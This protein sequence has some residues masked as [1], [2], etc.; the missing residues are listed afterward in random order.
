MKNKLLILMML[1]VFTGICSAANPQVTL[2]LSGAV[3][4]DIVLEIYADKA[5]VTAANFLNYV[6]T[7]FYDGLI[8]HRV[9]SGFMVQGGGFDANL[10]YKTA[11]SEIINESTNGLSN[12]RGTLAMARLT[13]PH[14]ASSQ[15]FINHV[16]N[17]FLDFGAV[18]YNAGTAYYRAGYCVFG[19]VLSGLDIVDAIAVLPTSTQNEM[20][21]VPDNDVIIH[22]VVTFDP[23]VC[24][25][26]E[27][28]DINGD[29]IVDLLDFLILAE[30]WLYGSIAADIDI[31]GKINYDDYSMFASHWM[32]QSCI[33]P[34]WCAG[35]DFNKNGAVDTPDALM[36]AQRWLEGV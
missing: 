11:G 28:G 27:Q 29:C 4:G 25:L 13:A 22:A 6:R 23:S 20:D 1:S 2:Y 32:Q 12:L 24:A 19:K 9:I 10:V 34:N 17:T 18:A 15:F 21:D 33:A 35:T 14:T 7:G 26:T 5:P 16:D 36:L 31:N 3:T 8:F 30:H